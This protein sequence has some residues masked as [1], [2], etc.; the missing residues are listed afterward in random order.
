MLPPLRLLR[1]GAAA[2]LLLTLG[3]QPAP[4]EACP[5]LATKASLGAVKA[6]KPGILTIKVKNV[7]STV[8]TAVGVAVALPLGASYQ[9]VAW[10]PNSAAAG[11]TLLQQNN[12]VAWTGLTIAAGR[13]I[14]IRV[15]LDF[16]K[17]AVIPGPVGP[18]TTYLPKHNNAAKDPNVLVGI[19]TF[20][21][22]TVPTFTGTTVNGAA[23]VSAIIES[24][25]G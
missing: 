12:T 13:A 25:R 2:A 23:C 7:G 24:V 5:S 6:T 22:T 16:D 4:A 3:A 11:L 21:G 8:A 19:A 15:K 9:S 10:K 1:L 18:V 14:A 17:C 20:T